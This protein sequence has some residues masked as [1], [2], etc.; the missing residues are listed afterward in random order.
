MI[1]I[2]ADTDRRASLDRMA[3]DLFTARTVLYVGA[4]ARRHDFA[5][6]F[7]AA[8]AVVDVLEAWPANF[9]AL[10][11]QNGGGWINLL[12]EG[13]VRDAAICRRYDVV[14]W[15]H[16][17]EHLAAEDIAPTVARLETFARRYVVLGSPWGVYDQ[18]A[19]GGNPY[20]V[21]QTPIWPDN[22]DALGYDVECLGRPDTRGSN[23]TAVKRIK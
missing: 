2:V 9:D 16:G 18:G 17:P 14:F 5:E 12:I 23:L 3:A 4:N 20:E 7:A 11:A 22:L 1:A 6:D 21:H 8:G 15:W 10:A 19:T 13:D